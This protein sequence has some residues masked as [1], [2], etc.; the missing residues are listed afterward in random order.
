MCLLIAFIENCMGFASILSIFFI[1]CDR[2]YVICKPLKVKSRMTQARTLKI[3]LLIWIVAIS[4]N[5]PLIFLSEYSLRRFA[6]NG[7]YEYRCDAKSTST[8][9]FIYIV[10]VAF[11]FYVAIGIV[12]VFMYAKISSNLRKST[13]FLVTSGNMKQH[14]ESLNTILLTNEE[15]LN[16]LVQLNRYVSENV[17]V[18]SEASNLNMNSNPSIIPMKNKNKNSL[19][20]NL[21]AANQHHLKKIVSDYRGNIEAI[22]SQNNYLEKYIKQ[23][24]QVVFMLMCVLCTFYI[25]LFPLKL[26][27]LVIMFG[28]NWRGFFSFIGFKRYWYIN[29][30]VRNFFYLNSSINPIL[31]NCLSQKFRKSFKK[32][33]IFKHCFAVVDKTKIKSTRISTL[34]ESTR[35][36]KKKF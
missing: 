8:W 13:H 10:S 21:S 32:L 9:S 23:R 30:T 36:N 18:N 5:F 17:N 19:T 3:I 31:Y 4:V 34:K 27:S 15:P 16:A 14:R 6:D 28:S 1:T 26:W 11:V 12:L 22:S 35:S 29:V 33:C 7:K 24:R 25:C 20:Q 2:Y